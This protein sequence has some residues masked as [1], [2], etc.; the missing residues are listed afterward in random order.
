[1]AGSSSWSLCS[2]G[3]E[4][5]IRLDRYKLCVINATARKSS[6]INLSLMCILYASRS[7]VVVGGVLAGEI[8]KKES[9]STILNHCMPNKLNDRSQSFLIKKILL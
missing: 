3:R 6:N 4:E 7:L 8:I 2:G 9:V 1:M 5:R